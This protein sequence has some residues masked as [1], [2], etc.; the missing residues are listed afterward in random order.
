MTGG[1]R[2]RPATVADAPAIFELVNYY[3]RQA[4]MLPKSHNQIY[5][6][7]RDFRVV[8]DPEGRVVGCGALHVVWGD[9]AEIRS[10]AIAEEYKGQGLGHQLVIHLLEDARAL[11]MPTVFALTYAPEFFKSLGFEETDKNT[12]PHKIWG[13]CIDCPKFPNCDEIALI[14]DLR[15]E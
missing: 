10:L 13:D 2:I 1:Y 5:Q 4:Q 6:N 15:R 12:L 8:T 3:A 11:G 7:I 14:K 9:L